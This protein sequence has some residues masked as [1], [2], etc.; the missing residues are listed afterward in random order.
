MHF[1]F[2]LLKL[3]CIALF[4]LLC[5]GMG[6]LP[7][8]RFMKDKVPGRVMRTFLIL[9]GSLFFSLSAFFLTQLH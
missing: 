7:R 2:D 6:F 9:G 1:S 4:G 3:S 8:D 5:I